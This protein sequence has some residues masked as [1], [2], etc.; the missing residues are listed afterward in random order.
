MKFLSTI[1]YTKAAELILE[2]K[3]SIAEISY[4][5]GF[6]NPKYFST[7]FKSSMEYHPANMPKTIK[8]NRPVI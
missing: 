5:T 8:T 1:I 6:P 2:N 7:A 3:Y 4:M